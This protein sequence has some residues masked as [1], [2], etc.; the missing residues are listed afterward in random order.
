MGF[1]DLFPLS[2]WINAV[3]KLALA[4]CKETEFQLVVSKARVHIDACIILY[5]NGGS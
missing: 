2:P 1:V 3:L 5:N 4:L